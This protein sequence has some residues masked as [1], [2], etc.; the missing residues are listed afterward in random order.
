MWHP[1]LT[2]APD[3]A[4]ILTCSKLRGGIFSKDKLAPGTAASSARPF[5]IKIYLDSPYSTHHL[6]FNASFPGSPYAL[7]MSCSAFTNP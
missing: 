6:G 4:L 3:P 5:R 1:G 7:F 2:G